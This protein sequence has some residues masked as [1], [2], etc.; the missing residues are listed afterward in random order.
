MNEKT[1]DRIEII[2]Y[3]YHRDILQELKEEIEKVES[4]IPKPEPATTLTHIK[5]YI[6]NNVEALENLT[7]LERFL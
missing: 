5:T 2:L 1:L 7:A 6:D 3:G 4:R